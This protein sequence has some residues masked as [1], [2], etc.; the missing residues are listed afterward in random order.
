[1]FNGE[2]TAAAIS[3]APGSTLAKVAGSGR[4]AVDRLNTLFRIG[5]SRPATKNEQKVAAAIYRRDGEAL[6][7]QDMW[8]AVLNSNEFILQ[9]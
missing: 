2:L 6:M 7:L 5:L 4:N 9:H 8:W 1:M 3:D